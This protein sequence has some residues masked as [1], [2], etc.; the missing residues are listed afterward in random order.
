MY[1]PQL[2]SGPS[3]VA[4]S[5]DSTE[6]MYAMAGSLWRQKIGSSVA[7]QLTASA[8]YDYQPDWSPDGRWVIYCSYDGNA[9]EL[10]A[11]D[12]SSGA[13]RPLTKN[14][15]VNVEPRF[16]PDGKRIVFTSTL[17][18]KR[19]HLFTADFRG[20]GLANIQRLTG[21]HKSEVPRTI[22]RS[23]RSGPA[24]GATFSMYPIATTSTAPA[25]SGARRRILPAAPQRAT[26]PPPRRNFITRK[27]IGRRVPMSRPTAR[28]WCTAPTSGEP[29]TIYG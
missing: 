3:S 29:G 18:N 6:L 17:Y 15:A 9:V 10:W 23:I 26:P 19:F 14:G 5:P 27:R 25:D 2:T 4:W 12:L 22:T 11:L 1:L 21:E 13:A 7:Q 20:G 28:G 16:S 24:T 8:A